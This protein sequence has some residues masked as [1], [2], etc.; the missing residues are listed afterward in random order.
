MMILKLSW[1][2]TVPGFFF[3]FP[4]FKDHTLSVCLAFTLD[5]WL[6]FCFMQSQGEKL[7]NCSKSV[8][9]QLWCPA[10]H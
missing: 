9:F 4:F 5:P 3:F 6:H 2:L 10:W 7:T 8:T 1:P